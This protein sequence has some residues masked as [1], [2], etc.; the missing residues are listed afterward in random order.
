MSYPGADLDQLTTYIT[1][2]AEPV[3]GEAFAAEQKRLDQRY[4]RARILITGG[5]GFIASHTLR[6]LLAFEPDLVCV[7]DTNENALAELVR[8]LRGSGLV[9]ARTRLEPRL[10]DVRTPLFSRMVRE[11]GPFDS[12]LAFAAAKHVRSERDAVSGLH[13]LDT[14]VNGT[15]RAVEAVLAGNGDA[16]IFVVSTDKAADPSSLMGASKR[17]MEMAVLGNYPVATSTRF[18]NV[19][20]SSGSL[21]ENWLIRLARKQ[22]LP[23]PDSTERFFVSPGEAGQLC[24]LASVAP[25]GSIVVPAPGAVNSADLR[26]ALGRL[27][28]GLGVPFTQVWDEATLA[29]YPSTQTTVLITPRDTAGEKAA[30]VFLG[31]HERARDWLPNLSLISGEHD[32]TAGRA[33]GS[34]IA[35]SVQAMPGPALP[36]VMDVVAT[37]VPGFHHVNSAKRLDD[38]I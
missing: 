34:W 1:G 12:L 24:A 38:R 20:F 29:Q 7:A 19:A 2:R 27:L 8:D 33:L 26:A 15:L 22:V 36:E 37:L 10:V 14:N 25:A 5:A 21:L 32:G 30:E 35:D 28:E 3:F 11:I 17:A 18:A 31:L 16:A 6:K 9:G 13:M 4:R 23:V